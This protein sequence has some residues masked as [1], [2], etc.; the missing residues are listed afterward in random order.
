[1]KCAA[2]KQDAAKFA[3]PPAKLVK[4]MARGV[5]L[6]AEPGWMVECRHCGNWKV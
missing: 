1:M 2:V 5:V 6:A 3:P 4:K